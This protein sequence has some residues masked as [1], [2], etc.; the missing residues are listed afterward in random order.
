MLNLVLCIHDFVG[1]EKTWKEVHGCVGDMLQRKCEK[2]KES[3]WT[4]DSFF[5]ISRAQPKKCSYTPG[6][7]T[8]SYTRGKMPTMGHFSST[9]NVALRTACGQQADY[10]QINFYCVKSEKTYFLTNS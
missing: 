8:Q 1:V 7:C 10:R 4:V 9:M 5:G 2:D 3:I 6:D